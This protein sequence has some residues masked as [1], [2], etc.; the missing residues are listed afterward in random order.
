MQKSKLT[1]PGVAQVE[2]EPVEMQEPQYADS[3]EALHTGSQVGKDRRNISSLDG[4]SRADFKE[5]R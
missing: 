2:S 1:C 4:V 5:E 3:H